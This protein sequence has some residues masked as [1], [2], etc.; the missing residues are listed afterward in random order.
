[1]VVILGVLL[2][3]LRAGLQADE[4]VGIAIEILTK[5]SIIT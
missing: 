3:V 1:M 4:S 2:L 5:T